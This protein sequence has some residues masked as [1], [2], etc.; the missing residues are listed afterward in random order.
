MVSPDSAFRTRLSVMLRAAGCRVISGSSLRKASADAAVEAGIVDCRSTDSVVRE[1]SE[2]CAVH[3]DADWVAVVPTEKELDAAYGAGAQAALPGSASDAA[4]VA[5]TLR[6]LDG[7]S[8]RRRNSDLSR[9]LRKTA[10][11]LEQ[12]RRHGEALREAARSV[13]SVDDASECLH[14]LAQLA[15]ATLSALRVGVMVGKEG[16]LGTVAY[17]GDGLSDAMLCEPSV[18]RLV[19]K[20]ARDK[21]PLLGGGGRTACAPLACGGELIGVLAAQRPASASAF[22]EDELDLLCALGHQVAVVVE[23]KKLYDDLRGLYVGT[24]AALAAAIDA[25]SCYTRLHSEIVTK[26]AM[27]TAELLDLD[28]RDNKTL[29]AACQLHDIGKIAVP[30]AVL[31]KPGP[32]TPEEWEQ[33]RLHPVRGHEILASSGFL[34][35]IA[36]LVR[37]HHERFDGKGYPDGLSGSEIPFL[38]RLICIA[39]A[40][41][42][43]TAQRPYKK[44]FTFDEAVAEVMRVS[45]TQ[46]DPNLCEPFVAAA[47]RLNERALAEEEAY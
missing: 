12:F 19:E 36:S 24:M 29:E 21:R 31:A 47:R 26:L 44:P 27:E 40:F 45:G 39:D 30:D 13:S 11:S 25:K 17:A 33:I 9:D 7:F 1:L 2:V 43:M 22:S 3:P 16:G 6:T 28:D 8:L 23:N 15:Q 37:S 35:E 20:V 5:A 41:E 34:D 4:V 18:S 42:A 10:D 14:N 38:A 46:F 32:L